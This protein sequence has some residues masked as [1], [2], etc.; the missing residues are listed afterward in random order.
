MMT[1]RASSVDI[2]GRRAWAAARAGLILVRGAVDG[3]AIEEEEG[4]LVD[5]PDA[6][7]PATR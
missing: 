3:V 4:T 1:V 7:V 5:G 2:L 6:A